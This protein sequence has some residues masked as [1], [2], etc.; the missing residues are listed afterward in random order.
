[1]DKSKIVFRNKRTAF[2]L[3]LIFTL[4]TI[5]LITPDLNPVYA[6]GIQFFGMSQPSN[7]I[8]GNPTDRHGF[9]VV[10]TTNIAKCNIVIDGA[11]RTYVAYDSDAAGNAIRLYYSNS[12]NGP[13]SAYSGNP[14]LYGNGLYRT[15]SVTYVNGVFQMFLDA[16]NFHDIERWTSTNGITFT[17][18]ETVLTT[19]YDP[20]TNP[21]IWLNPNDKNWYLF[22][23]RGN[24]AAGWWEIM[25]RSSTTITGLKSKTDTVVMH[26]STPYNN[27]FPT[28]AYI[29][30]YY[31]LLTEA[32]SS[33][34]TGTWRVNAWYSTKV[35]SGYNPTIDSPIL[36]NDEACPEFFISNDGKS[37]YL[38]TNQNINKW[39]Q[40]VRTVYVSVGVDTTPPTFSL[41]TTSQTTAGSPSSFGVTWSD[42]VGLSKYIFSFDNG[43]GS[44]ANIS[45]SAFSTNPQTISIT[46][47]LNP[48]VGATIRYRWFAN[49]T[50]NNWNTTPIQS[51]TTI[52]KSSKKTFGQT[53]V[54]PN[55]PDDQAE[56][57]ANYKFATRFQAPENGIISQISLYVY[58]ATGA[59]AVA[60]FIVYSDSGGT[61]GTLLGTSNEVSIPGDN[62]YAWRSGSLSISIQGGKYYWIGAILGNNLI[63]RKYATGSTGQ[64]S[65]NP[66]AYSDGASN[67]WGAYN[68]ENI[69]YSIFATYTPS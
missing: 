16:I 33:K 28:I 35:T 8:S 15:P 18:A 13:W 4:S 39:Y 45:T 7:P 12:V 49:D 5:V 50:S 60:K 6:A 69:V 30:G 48:T 65:W 47:T 9:S 38:F 22:W 1:M 64:S 59:P 62:T 55:G 54:L 14:I 58:S 56:H 66:D 29:N 41:V 26:V 10:H 21:F 37:Y 32:L 2:F 23:E 57:D 34:N 20:W 3:I 27:A 40:E 61:P 53:S 46:E 42:N 51:F 19:P 36:T 24:D 17:K 44:F 11:A 67:T 68:P 63:Q 52:L 31:W 25:A 43:V